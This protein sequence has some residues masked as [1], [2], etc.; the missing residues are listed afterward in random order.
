MSPLLVAILLGMLVASLARIPASFEPGISFA[1]RP[2][3]RWGVAGLGFRL[4]VQ[5]LAKVGLPSLGVVV[6]ST[7]AAL[8]FGWWAARR[9]GMGPRPGILLSVGGAIC[10]AS[11]VIAADSVVQAEKKDSAVALGV[12]TLLGT[13][14]IFL[15]PAIYHLTGMSVGVYALWDGASLHE[16]AQVVAAGDM[17]SAQAATGATIVK[18]ARICLLAPVVFG[19]A[20]LL[21]HRHERAGRARVSAVPWFL[22][23]FLAIVALNSAIS[24]PAG[25]LGLI[26]DVDLAVLSIGMAGV[27]LHTGVREVR[28]AGIRPIVAGALQWAFLSAL[29]LCLALAI[30]R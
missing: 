1:Q 15:Y 24:L 21:R 11:A 27:G 10:G 9:L 23:A 20:W 7:F 13:V 30:G 22:V 3:L 6:V 17:V 25:L 16:M 29:A 28:E 5:E 8:W 26:R 4:D 18:L 12:V 14:G 19:L 2:L